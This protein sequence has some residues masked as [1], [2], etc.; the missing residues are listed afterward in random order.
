VVVRVLDPAE[1]DL[2]FQG[3]VRLRALEGEAVVEA[4]ADLVRAGYKERLASIGA[5]WQVDLEARGGRL[6]D[7]TTTDD[8][9]SVVRSVVLA[10]AEGRR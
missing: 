7:V 3:T 4:D 5:A 6:L 9:T 1:R 10:V 8:A 2:R